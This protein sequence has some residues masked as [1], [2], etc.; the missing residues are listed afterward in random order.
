MSVGA[1]LWG[2]CALLPGCGSK[3]AVSLSARIDNAQLTVQ[4]ATLGT[5]LSGKFDLVLELGEAA[6]R[7]TEVQLGA[8]SLKNDHGVLVER[9]AL[10][11]EPFPIS[12]AVGTTR[13]VPFT[14]DDSELVT[15]GSA[16]I[17]AGPV[18]IGGSVSDSLSNGKASNVTSSMLAIDC[19]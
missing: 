11:S 13:S 2:A 12:V 19:P 8:F 10:E 14:L 7:A 6:P 16:E 5:K 4:D 9:L 18:Y 15:P 3:G 1:L 17:C